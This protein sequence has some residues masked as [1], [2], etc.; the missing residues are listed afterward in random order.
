MR[1]AVSLKSLFLEHSRNK[2]NTHVK[3]LK[4]NKFGFMDD[5]NQE[6]L[7]KFDSKN[8]VNDGYYE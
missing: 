8:Y 2:N 6:I 5:S 3:P 1:N 4:Q 7:W